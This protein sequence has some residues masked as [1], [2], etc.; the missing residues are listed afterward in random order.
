MK[1]AI[2]LMMASMAGVIMAADPLMGNYT[3]TK[4]APKKRAKPCL[5]CDTEHDHNNA[6]C[7]VECCKEWKQQEKRDG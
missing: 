7:S 6:W 4:Y 5:Q 3:P 1:V 2:K